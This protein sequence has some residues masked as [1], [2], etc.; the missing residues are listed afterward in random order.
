M[1]LSMLIQ[2]MRCLLNHAISSILLLAHLDRP[3][4]SKYVLQ[5]ALKIFVEWMIYTIYFSKYLCG[6]AFYEATWMHQGKDPQA[7]EPAVARQCLL[8]PADP[9]WRPPTPAQACWLLPL[10]AIAKMMPVS[11]WPCDC[12]SQREPTR[13]VINLPLYFWKWL[14]SSGMFNRNLWTCCSW[15]SFEQ[16]KMS[17]IAGVRKSD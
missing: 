16:F 13:Q 7:T 5:C 10:F 14:F 9:C 2:I 8:T 12:M 11:S 1:A 3:V 15:S 4:K 17:N 6:T